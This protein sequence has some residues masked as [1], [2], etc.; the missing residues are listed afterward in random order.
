MGMKRSLCEANAVQE[1][2]GG[3]NFLCRRKT[4]NSTQTRDR[5]S[6][7]PGGFVK[8]FPIL[9]IQISLK[10]ISFLFL[11]RSCQGLKFLLEEKTRKLD[12]NKR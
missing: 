10:N 1:P 11:N 9:L 5:N 3:S 6:N 2:W 8:Q 12:T 7:Y 4:G